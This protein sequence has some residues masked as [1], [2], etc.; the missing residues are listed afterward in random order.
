MLR[1]HLIRRYFAC[2]FERVMG[3]GAYA[4]TQIEM[5]VSL[6]KASPAHFQRPLSP[7]SEKFL[8]QHIAATA[9]YAFGL[10]VWIDR[11]I[12]H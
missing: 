5:P 9:I 12:I 4:D 2:G 8:Q 10:A 3:L 6:G 11:F 7:N 1:R